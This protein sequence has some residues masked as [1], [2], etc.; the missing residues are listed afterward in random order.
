MPFELIWEP[1]GVYRRYFGR[2][3]IS[4]RRQSFDRICGDPRFDDL[5][6]AI[7]DYLGVESYEITPQATEEIAAMHI[8]P[9]RT[10]PAIIIAA[11]VVDQRILAA[12]DHF[13]SLRFFT[14]PYRIFPTVDA[15]RR[16]VSGARSAQV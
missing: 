4:Q 6:Y 13:I 15:A 7:T 8:A 16:W 14:Q 5:R 3:T 9:M 1:S 2:V 10:N 11:V 12:I